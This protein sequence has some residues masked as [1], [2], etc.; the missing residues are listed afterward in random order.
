MS[1]GIRW[2]RNG[3]AAEGHAFFPVVKGPRFA[4]SMMTGG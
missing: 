2:S 4:Q 1:V 3:I